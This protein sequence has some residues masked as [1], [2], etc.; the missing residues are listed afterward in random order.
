MI[1][2]SSRL[3]ARIDA[4]ALYQPPDGRPP[5]S[6]SASGYSLTDLYDGGLLSDE[7]ML[8]LCEVTDVVA[9][10]GTICEKPRLL[11]AWLTAFEIHASVHEFDLT[12]PLTI[13]TRNGS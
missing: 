12:K 6:L 5:R 9:V 3:R 11:D 7:L 8:A 4:L 2:L 10:D 13:E 1:S